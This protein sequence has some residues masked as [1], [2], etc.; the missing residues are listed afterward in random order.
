M[1]RWESKETERE[2]LRRAI[3]RQLIKEEL[4]RRE[5]EEL[6]FDV[7][8][9]S[10]FGHIPFG[11]TPSHHHRHISPSSSKSPKRFI[12]YVNGKEVE[13]PRKKKNTKSKLKRKSCSCKKN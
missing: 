10:M 5:L 7:H 9:W 11:H 1:Y 6:P 8:S 4:E 3:L 12:T 13:G 2:L